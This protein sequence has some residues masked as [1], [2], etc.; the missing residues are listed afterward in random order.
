[1][2]AAKS[3]QYRQALFFLQINARPLCIRLCPGQLDRDGNR[4][5]LRIN[6]NADDHA[7]RQQAGIGVRKGVSSPLD[8]HAWVECAG[9]PVNDRPNIGNEFAVFDALDTVVMGPLR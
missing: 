2:F 5:L 1:M 4:L 8:A 6:R 3:Y 7:I 9:I